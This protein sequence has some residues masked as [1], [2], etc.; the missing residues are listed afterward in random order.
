[1]TLLLPLQAGAPPTAA[2]EGLT[3]LHLA[4]RGGHHLLLP[5]LVQVDVCVCVRVCV[6]ACVCVCARVCACA[7]VR[8]FMCVFVCLF[9]FLCLY[10]FAHLQYILPLAVAC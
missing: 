5:L 7:R 10:V 6:C 8:L 9:V 1:M 2:A 4:A 3:P